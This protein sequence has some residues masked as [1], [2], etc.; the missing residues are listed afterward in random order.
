MKRSKLDLLKK[1]HG[2]QVCQIIATCARL[3][4]CDLLSKSPMTLFELSAHLHIPIEPLERFIKALLHLNIL[5]QLENQVLA[6]T[7]EGEYLISTKEGTLQPIAVYK[8]APFMW[9]ALSF[10]Y[11]GLLTNTSPFELA[12]GQS[13]FEFLETHPESF[14]IFHEAMEFYEKNSSKRILDHYDFSPFSSLLDVGCGSGSFTQSLMQKNPHLHAEGF[15][16]PS[17]AKKYQKQHCV[18]IPGDFFHSIPSNYDCYVLRNIIHDW[19]DEKGVEILSNLSKAMYPQSRALLFETILKPNGGMG[20]FSDLNLFVSTPN[21]KERTFDELKALIHKAKLNCLQ[22]IE[23]PGSSKVI[24]EVSKEYI[25]P[26]QEGINA[27]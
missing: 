8:G 27:Y 16:L 14:T 25:P 20:K 13:L 26:E 7:E 1:I 22:L 6:V 4:L 11:E 5:K 9:N 10:L 24:I 21:G 18:I 15:D 23:C 3:K 2:G 19:N 12:H 17:V